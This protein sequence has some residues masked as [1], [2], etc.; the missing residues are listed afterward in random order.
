MKMDQSQY[1]NQE[2]NYQS[3][4][5]CNRKSESFIKN[6]YCI[7]LCSYFHVNRHARRAQPVMKISQVHEII[8]LPLRRGGA[9]ELF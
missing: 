3:A 1:K 5:N 2:T 6:I 9:E 4:G 7:S 8:I